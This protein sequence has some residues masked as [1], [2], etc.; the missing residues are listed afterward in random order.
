MTVGFQPEALAKRRKVAIGIAILA[1]F[2]IYSVRQELLGRLLPADVLI[3]IA[4]QALMVMFCVA[5]S[6]IVQKNLLHVFR[7]IIFFTWPVSVPIYFF[8]ARGSKGLLRVGMYLL[9]IIAVNVM[10]FYGAY[11]LKVYK[12]P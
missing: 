2:G 7:W 3:G 12:Q 10:A 9:L 6:H 4:V 1:L 11:L 8:W 5:D